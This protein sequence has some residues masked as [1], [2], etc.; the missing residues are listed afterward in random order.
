MIKFLDVVYD[1]QKIFIN[2]IDTLLSTLYTEIHTSSTNHVF[3]DIGASV[4]EITNVMLKYVGNNG[5]IIA[6][7]AHPNWLNE[8][9]LVSN[10]FVKTH[11]IGCY[12]NK[13][14]LKFM[15]EDKLTGL[16]FIK[17][18][19]SKQDLNF[20]KIKTNE[21]ECDTLDNILQLTNKQQVTFIKIDTEAC[22]FEV[23]LGA[24]NIIK[25]HRP[26]IVFEF[27]GTYMEIAHPHDRN[28]FFK[29]FKEN[30]YILRSVCFGKNERDISRLRDTFSPELCDI[31]AIPIEYK[32]LI[33]E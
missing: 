9:T 28:D 17:I 33:H 26:F 23:I 32:G 18:S 15:C 10:S 2:F 21:I 4:G 31:I 29:F 11:N 8:F 7:D 14:I 6:I 25:Q 22:D 19:P 24:S 1:D 27:S 13:S 12:S 3:V 5:N 30:K 16:G 20:S